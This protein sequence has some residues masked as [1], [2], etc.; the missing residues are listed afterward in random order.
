VADFPVIRS[1]QE[2]RRMLLATAGIGV[3]FVL[4]A[5]SVP[6]D[7]HALDYRTIASVRVLDRHGT[8]LRTTLG[9]QGTAAVWTPLSNMSPYLI[10]AT[11]AAEDKRFYRHP[12]LDPLATL[13]AAWTDLAQHKL[14]AGGSTITQQLAGMLW[15]EPRTI[16]GKLREAVR[17][18]RLEMLYSKNAILEQYLNRAPYGPMIQGVGAASEAYFQVS[19]DRMGPAQAATLAALPQAPT[20][21]TSEAGKG[22]LRRRRDH[23]LALLERSGVLGAEAAHEAGERPIELLPHAQTRGAP[24]FAD[25]V[26]ASLPAL[27]RTATSLRTT[28]DARLQKDVEAIVRE[29]ETRQG[30]AATQVAVVVE[31]LPSAEILAMVGSLDWTDPREGQVNATLARRQPGSALKPFFYALAFDRGLSP[32]DPLADV[33]MHFVDPEGAD[34]SPRNFDGRYHGPVRARV[35]LA[36]SFNVPAVR[37]QERVGIGRAIEGLRNAGLGDFANDADQYGLGL[38]LGVGEVTLLDLTT[39]YAGLARGGVWQP[40][41]YLQ[42]ADDSRGC[43]L[44]LS[45]PVEK[46]WCRAS[47]AFLV[48]DILADDAARTPGFGNASV[49]DLPFP[50][51]VK[52]G[53]STGYRDAWCVGFDGDH[54][55]GVWTGNFDGS[56]AHG[57]GGV[58]TAGPIFREIA[59]YLHGRGSRPW[60]AQPP[61]GWTERVVCALSGGRPRDA[62][63][64]TV[65]EWFNDRDWSARRPCSFHHWRDGRREIA[66]PAGYREWAAAA[67]LAPAGIDASGSPQITSPTGGSVYFLDP[68]L[69]E[70]A[71]I[72]VAA[73]NA[74]VDARWSMDGSA[75]A[76]P[77]G[78]FYW[79]PVPGDHVVEVATPAGRDVVRFSVR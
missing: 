76:M 34:L 70:A 11:I 27:L 71:G 39:A 3:A 52:T 78:D 43:A 33:P 69:G 36:S 60:V 16:P 79:R 22:A 20:W 21:L 57:R 6:F 19:P 35:A 23:V 47:S 5:T 1:S 26:L 48:E 55:I 56:P 62:C 65:L 73:L 41:T 44:P 64:G 63:A 32:A 66:W 58:R 68:R 14:V 24:H 53:T 40:P 2:R 28:L 45:S 31:T 75:I 74:G 49:I 59:I 29:A 50:V 37:V 30:D 61:P 42:E 13:R 17:A 54:V 9:N 18:V 12:G 77:G 38:T 25:W 7:T 15:P 51:V 8:P 67:D 72:R 46:R 10:Q 4:W